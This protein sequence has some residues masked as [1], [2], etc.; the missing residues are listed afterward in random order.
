MNP[1]S[2]WRSLP[3]LSRNGS[4]CRSETTYSVYFEEVPQTV[5]S[6]KERLEDLPPSAKLVYKTLEYEGEGTQK[7][8]VTETR[9]S[10]RTVRYA[11]SRLEEQELVE[12]RVSF[13]D[14]RQKL[15]S[16]AE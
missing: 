12:Q 15:Y 2:T 10:S 1:G 6:A 11:I 14:A 8:L 13:R 7:E 4:N 5:S 3:V 16:L 9:L